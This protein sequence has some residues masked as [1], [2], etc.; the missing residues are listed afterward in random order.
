METKAKTVETPVAWTVADGWVQTAWGDLY[1]SRQAAYADADRWTASRR[2]FVTYAYV[3]EW[4]GPGPAER[5][6]SFDRDAHVARVAAHE[7]ALLAAA[8]TA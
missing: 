5:A 2:R 1:P 8:V 6:A 4:D 7:A 3:S